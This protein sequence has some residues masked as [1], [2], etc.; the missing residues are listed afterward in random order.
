MYLFWGEFSSEFALKSVN[1]R[2][3]CN[4]LRSRGDN[5]EFLIVPLKTPI[6]AASGQAK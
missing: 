6:F 2:L 3:N 5:E 1:E 4:I